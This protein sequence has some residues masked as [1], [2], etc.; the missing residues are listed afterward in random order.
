MNKQNSTYFIE[1]YFPNTFDEVKL[2]ITVRQT[3]DK[4]LSNKTFRL[5]L[6][7]TPGTG[8][9][10]S[11]RILSKEYE[12]LYLSGSNNFLIDTM[13]NKIYPFATGHSVIGKPK[14]IIIDECENIRDNLQD[15]F[16][17]A[18]DK[19]QSV[20][21]I[22][23]TNEVAKVNDAIKSRCEQI[24]FDFSGEELKQQ[25]MNFA[26]QI[27]DICVAEEIPYDT[28]GIKKLVQLLYPDFRQLIIILQKLK[29]LNQPL[30]VETIANLNK[31]GN[32]N[33]DLYSIVMNP[34]I[35][36]KELYE[37]VSIYKGKEKECLQSL[38]EPFFEFLID[39][40]KIDF[41]LKCAVLVSNYS[42]AYNNS[43]NKFTSLLGLIAELKQLF[44]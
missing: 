43:I 18:L 23:I 5:L 28:D 20:S 38:G 17:I 39:E 40:G 27:R 19:M 15:A 34:A 24:C 32:Q 1:K 42:A 41:V 12:T 44:K 21:F 10:S 25:K 31:T 11:A 37:R 2:P 36:G 35:N 22:F 4:C 6:H 3:F 7:G 26:K 13:N 9:T 16:K 14:L 8:K 33:S 29:N 30:S